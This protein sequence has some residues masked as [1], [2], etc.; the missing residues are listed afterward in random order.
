MD[1]FR[2][3]LSHLPDRDQDGSRPAAAAAAA[4]AHEPTAELPSVFRSHLWFA[5][6]RPAKAGAR[7]CRRA[8]AV[9]IGLGP[10]CFGGQL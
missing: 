6:G 8:V 4:G 9:R 1:T 7:L 3:L 10:A 5:G 2:G